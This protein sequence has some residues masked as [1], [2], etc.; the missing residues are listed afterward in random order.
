[1]KNA[2]AKCNMNKNKKKPVIEL[3]LSNKTK[4]CHSN[5]NNNMSHVRFI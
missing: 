4:T 2:L 3:K 5:V 1:M